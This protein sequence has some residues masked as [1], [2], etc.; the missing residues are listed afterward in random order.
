M[1][2]KNRIAVRFPNSEI[3][4]THSPTFRILFKETNSTSLINE[5]KSLS[6]EKK[7]IF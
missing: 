5:C 6:S 7:S 3:H 1:K 4:L 2:K